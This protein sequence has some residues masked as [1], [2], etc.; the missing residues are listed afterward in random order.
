VLAALFYFLTGFG[1]TGGY[2]RLW[3]HKGWNAVAPVRFIVLMFG[4]AALQGSARWWCR[5]HRAHHKF[6]DTTKVQKD[7]GERRTCTHALTT[8]VWERRRTRTTCGQA[9][10]TRTLAG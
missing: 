5:N 8:F 3:S 7:R 6:T 10:C 4:A 9:L 1:I 2:H